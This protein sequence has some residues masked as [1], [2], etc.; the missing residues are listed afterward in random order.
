[1]AIT[2]SHRTPNLSPGMSATNFYLF[3]R[4]PPEVRI[5]IYKE[6]VSV[7]RLLRLDLGVD[8]PPAL[9]HTCRESRGEI[10]KHFTMHQ[11]RIYCD[12]IEDGTVQIPE[13]FYRIWINKNGRDILHVTPMERPFF[14]AT[15]GTQLDESDLA[16]KWVPSFALNNILAMDTLLWV[17]PEGGR[18]FAN[19]R[20]IMLECGEDQGGLP[21]FPNDAVRARRIQV[22][23]WTQLYERFAFADV[24][25][26][27]EG[28]KKL[29]VRSP[30][31]LVVRRDNMSDAARD[32]LNTLEIRA[33]CWVVPTSK[34]YD[35]PKGSGC[36]WRAVKRERKQLSEKEHSTVHHIE[37]AMNETVWNW[38]ETATNAETE[39]RDD[40]VWPSVLFLGEGKKS[41]ADGQ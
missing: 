22:S 36:T 13:A 11:G 37:A 14:A 40:P 41:R 30:E 9:L 10:Q 35:N 29:G 17:R 3:P 20:K 23:A 24:L 18:P 39:S 15:R 25:E 16:N 26:L 28:L 34:G 7:P 31:L 5:M 19:L 38:C 33:D 6:A 8:T 2:E 1:M 4:L 21:G 27:D 12:G 32:D